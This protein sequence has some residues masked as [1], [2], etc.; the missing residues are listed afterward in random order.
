MQYV[1]YQTLAS[2]SEQQSSY[3]CGTVTK[4]KGIPQYHSKADRMMAKVLNE[5]R[6]DEVVIP[7]K[8]RRIYAGIAMI[9]QARYV[10]RKKVCEVL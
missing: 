8:R 1:L 9:S 3:G 4:N 6:R 5:R 10:L 2:S 7:F